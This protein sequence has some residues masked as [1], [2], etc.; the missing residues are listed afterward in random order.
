MFFSRL[1]THSLT[2]SILS[3]IS[4]LS[5]STAPFNMSVIAEALGT[6]DCIRLEI[7]TNERGS[8]DVPDCLQTGL[9]LCISPMV[10]IFVNI[11]YH[12]MHMFM[13][14]IH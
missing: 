4:R 7:S 14:S 2:S 5:S 3:M 10:D 1:S 9:H 6:L 8:V 13:H 12:G 11:S